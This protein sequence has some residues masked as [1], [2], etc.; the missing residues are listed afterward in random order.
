[1]IKNVSQYIIQYPEE[2]QKRLNLIRQFLL[3]VPGVQ[4]SISYGIPAYK[5]YK[6]PL[7]YFAAY[8]RHIGLYA[9]PRGHEEFKDKL[10][11]YKQG[12]GSV[13]FPNQEEF[14]IELIQQI[15]QFRL[16]E[17]QEKYHK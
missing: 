15:I 7:V 10:A 3:Q 8:P 12:K 16:N 9:T 11:K 17:N 2:I 14:P 6:K 4:E 1:M 5:T 13:Q